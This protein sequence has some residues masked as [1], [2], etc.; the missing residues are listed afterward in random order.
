MSVLLSIQPQWCELIASGKKTI[1]VRKTR[2]KLNTPFRVYIYCTN[3]KP[4]L[5]WRNGIVYTEEKDILG[6]RGVGLYQRLN[7]MVIGEFVCDDI[8]CFDTKNTIISYNKELNTC[9]TDEELVEYAGYFKPLYYWHI[10]DLKIYDKP[11]E[12]SNFRNPCQVYID[13][14]AKCGDCDYYYCVNNESYREEDCVVEGLKP[15]IRPPQSWC[16]VKK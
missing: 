13:G 3:G 6:G 9:M 2:P 7:K 12:L 15:I 14:T 4:Y 11:K 8:K 1:E 16:Y 10:S 5:N